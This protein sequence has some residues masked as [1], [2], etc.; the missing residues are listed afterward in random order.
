MTDRAKNNFRKSLYLLLLAVAGGYILTAWSF[1]QASRAQ[2]LLTED[3]QAKKEFYD[4]HLLN[5]FYQGRNMR[6]VWLRG[7]TNFQPRADG[8]LKIL[9][10]SWSHGLNPEKYHVLKLK[11]LS[12]KLT[13]DN[14]GQFDMLMTDGVIR[15]TR[16]LT[17]M[18]GNSTP[19]EKAARY[20]REPMN[21][22]AVLDQVALAADPVNKLYSLA[23]SGKLYLAL[24]KEL[25][26]LVSFSPDPSDPIK[27]GST[28]KPGR[29][30]AAVPRLRERL[31]LAAGN[32]AST[33]YDDNLA[34]AV[35]KVQR[36]NGLQADGVIRADTLAVLNRGNE[37]KIAQIMAN[38]ERLRWMDQTRPDRYVLV[39][40]PSAS[41]WAVDRGEVAL[42][43]PVIVG[44]TARPTYSFK[45]EISGVRFNPNWTVPP[46]IKNADFL[47][48]LQ[49]GST[50]LEERGIRITYNGK[51]VDPTKVDWSKITPH[52][53]K[54]VKMIQ[55]PGDDNPLG[56]V[57]VIMENPYNIYLHD[58]NHR[59]MF[60]GQE[61][62]LSSGCIRVSQPE[63]LADFILSKNQNWSWNGMEKMIDSGKM[64]DVPTEAKM[65]VYITYQTIWLDS[66]GKLIYGRDVYGQDEALYTLL[67]KRGG[68]H[69][70]Q[71]SEISQ[72]SL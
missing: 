24:R 21:A 61:R 69:I 6:T 11:E 71:P 37:A 44:K 3:L 51:E 53:L 32:P 5:D 12:A 13:G 31:G 9:E 29:A 16:D 60:E 55:G 14:R 63:K 19:D 26:S 30:D 40:I 62:A 48:A 39:N 50:V 46:T 28:L 57:R 7:Y 52:D 1:P 25:I 33:V 45:T 67:K 65:P 49:Q 27:I 15:Y 18:R 8:V 64:R 70:P 22:Q 72:I 41:L 43:M 38:M 4:S 58:T 2:A 10:Q 17:G 42:E 23:P 36:Q 68:I 35:M 66:E 47:P 59:E 54:K 34:A 56:K 20:W